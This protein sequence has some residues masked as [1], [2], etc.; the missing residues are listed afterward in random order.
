M[1]TLV[2][3]KTHSEPA[4]HR[5]PFEPVRA[6]IR[7]SARSTP[8]HRCDEAVIPDL[9]HLASAGNLPL[10]PACTRLVGPALRR[11]LQ[12]L[13]QLAHAINRHDAHPAVFLVRDWR[14]ALTMARP[15]EARL[16]HEAAR[17]L[18]DNVGYTPLRQASRELDAP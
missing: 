9:V 17:L 15:E 8:C 16:L 1:T 13:N 10:C 3:I 11:G 2:T 4:D 12:A 18:A 6:A 7:H 5:G 14:S